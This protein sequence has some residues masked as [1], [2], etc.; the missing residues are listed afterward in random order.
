MKNDFT[1]YVQWTLCTVSMNIASVIEKYLIHLSISG[2]FNCPR[3][4]V[5]VVVKTWNG[6][7]SRY[8]NDSIDDSENQLSQK[9]RRILID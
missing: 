7:L 5:P 4:V 6:P 3:A 8:H 2:M 1:E 9:K